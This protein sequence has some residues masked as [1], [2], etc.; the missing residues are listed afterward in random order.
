MELSSN[1][2]AS[3]FPKMKQLS[4]NDVKELL[5]E[6]EK[7]VLCVDSGSQRSPK[8]IFQL[9]YKIR[10]ENNAPQEKKEDEPIPYFIQHPEDFYDS[11]EIICTVNSNINS[12][13]IIKEVSDEK[14]KDKNK[15]INKE[16]IKISNKN[17]KMSKEESVESEINEESKGNTKSKKNNQ[18]EPIDIESNEEKEVANKNKNSKNTNVIKKGKEIKKQNGK[19][20]KLEEEEKKEE[21]EKEE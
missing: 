21:S 13:K 7:N 4:E 6:R 14:T 10:N 8:N 19:K 12:K 17:I 15:N 9:M 16:N 5:N 11:E 1:V 3:I 2:K 18:E 20:R